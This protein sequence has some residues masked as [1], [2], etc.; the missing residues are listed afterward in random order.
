M[1]VP[2]LSKFASKLSRVALP[3]EFVGPHKIVVDG[4][5]G[6]VTGPVPAP[7]L[8]IVQEPGP[9]RGAA[10]PWG[11]PPLA[12]L[13]GWAGASHR[14]LAKYSNIYLDQG[15]TTAQL[16]LPT[17]H[18]FRETEQIPEVMSEMVDQLESVGVRERPLVIH[19]LSDTGAMCYQ[20]LDLATRGAKLDIR[21]VV[22]DSSPGP[23]PEITLP[24]VAA[25]LA[26]NWFCAKGDGKTMAGATHSSY[27]LLID[28]GWPNYLRKLQGKSV[29][30]S[31]MEGVWAGHFGRDHYL[32]Y[33]HIP[34]LFLY[35][36]SDFYLNH[37]YLETQV[38]ARRRNHGANF[39]TKRFRGSAHVQHYRKNKA[40]YEAAVSNFLRSAWGMEGVEEEERVLVSHSKGFPSIGSFGI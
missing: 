9:G 33:P 5:T 38:L 40:E 6:P 21:G 28:R 25:L 32:Q 14:N 29:D 11:P 12:L 39:S 26:V 2:S 22:W 23:Y 30:L 35:S 4:N 1:A 34:E 24:C 7:V 37:K 31:L 36:N 8:P 10:G 27:R 15:C 19:C 3:A 20:G 18:V 13:F 16:T 17:R